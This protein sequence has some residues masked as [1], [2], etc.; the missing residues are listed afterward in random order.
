VPI[1]IKNL[2][3]SYNNKDFVLKNINLNIDDGQIVGIVG[4][5]GCGKSTLVQAI[6]GL[7]NANSGEILIDNDNIL[8]KKYNKMVLRK[9]L[10]IVFQYPEMQLFEQSVAKDITF[11]LKNSGISK[12]EKENRVKWA[13]ELL[14]LDYDKFKDKSPLALSGGEK[15]KVA[16][17]GVI[18]IKPKYLIL[19]E[20]IAGLDSTSRD[21]FMKLLFDLKSQG[22]TVIVVSHNADFLSQCA[23]EIIVMNDGNV[24]MQSSANDVFS[25]V[26][27]LNSIPL[28]TSTV[29]EICSMLEVRGISLSKSVLKYDDLADELVSVFCKNYE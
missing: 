22:T 16:I 6:A 14:H 15:R 28:G 4:K 27:L 13:M 3:L 7:V 17:A 9:K 2:S 23:D 25:N 12:S 11:S 19:D 1:E 10:G 5:T 24:V 8:D 29:K 20:P 26:E 18:V 21:D